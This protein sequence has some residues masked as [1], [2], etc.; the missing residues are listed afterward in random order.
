[1]HILNMCGWWG[2]AGLV[3]PG[4]V[5]PGENEVNEFVDSQWLTLMHSVRQSWLLWLRVRLCAV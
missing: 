3:S 1:M 4:G 5:A 2:S